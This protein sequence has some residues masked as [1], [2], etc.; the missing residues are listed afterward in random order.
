MKRILHLFQAP[1]STINQRPLHFAQWLLISVGVGLLPLWY[2][3]LKNFDDSVS[4]ESLKLYFSQK[5]L[6]MFSIALLAN[7]LSATFL[8]GKSGNSD[9]AIGIKAI[10]NTAC[11][12]LLLMNTGLLFIKP[13]AQLFSG[14][15]MF[16]MFLFLLS[17]IVAS[18]IYCFRESS[19]EKSAGAFKQEDDSAKENL[20][21]QASSVTADRNGV[22]V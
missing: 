1:L 5:G 10:A 11:L 20:K 4:F 22:K 15:N 2:A 7:G 8:A 16:Q 19:W 9:D 18:Y 14:T 13:N 3:V 17:I 21:N 12:I 6:T